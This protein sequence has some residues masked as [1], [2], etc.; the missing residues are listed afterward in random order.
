[1]NENADVMRSSAPS[2]AEGSLWK[3]GATFWGV[4]S[5]SF[6]KEDKTEEALAQTKGRGREKWGGGVGMG[7][8]GEGERD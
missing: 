6:S 5:P 1:M 7:E 8:G 4:K 3:R 2:R